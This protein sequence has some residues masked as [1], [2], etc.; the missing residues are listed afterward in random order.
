MGTVL[1]VLSGCRGGGHHGGSCD[2]SASGN[3]LKQPYLFP[4]S[5]GRVMMSSPG[6]Q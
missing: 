6:P 4:S 1:D 2:L 5:S 3:A